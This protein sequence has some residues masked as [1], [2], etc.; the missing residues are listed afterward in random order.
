MK[1]RDETNPAK[2]LAQERRN[3]KK[4]TEGTIDLELINKTKEN[5]AQGI[6]T[7]LTRER[8]R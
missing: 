2:K 3:F 7:T 4:R 6:Q 8:K 1:W 5:I